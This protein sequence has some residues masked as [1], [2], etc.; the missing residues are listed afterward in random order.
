MIELGQTPSGALILTCEY[1]PFPGGIATYASQLTKVLR[2]AGHSV[3]VIAPDYPDLPAAPDQDVQRLLRHH[4]FTPMQALAVL[5]AINSAPPD[6]LLLAADI[7]AVLLAALNRRL[8]GRPFRA[9]IHGSEVSKFGPRSPLRALV[10]GAYRSADVVCANSRATLEIFSANLGPLARGVVTYLGVDPGCF[11]PPPPAF[12]HP[13]LA[14]LA[15]DATIVCTVGRIEAR[16][17]HREAIEVVRLAQERLGQA[18][19]VYVAAG[20]VEDDDYA[21]AVQDEARERGVR[22]IFTGRLSD[23]DLA[24]L[25][26]ASLCHLLPAQELSGKIEGFGLVLIEAGARGCPS[27]ASRVGGIPEVLRETG[28]VCPQNDLAGMAEAIIALKGNSHLRR[29]LGEAARRNAETFNWTACARAT[30]PELSWPETA[31]AASP[32]VSA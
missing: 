7:R 30:F 12:E 13:E 31:P 17:G 27:I 28:F 32:A 5:R 3:G 4:A 9:M 26:A 16:K 6:R 20:R 25:Y 18:P 21:R 10:Q 19:L 11:E 14:S 15:D 23:G 22:A 29:K 24:R 1:A 8:G 2:E